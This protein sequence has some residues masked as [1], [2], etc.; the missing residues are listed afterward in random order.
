MIE[1]QNE[2]TVVVA[3][4]NAGKMLDV[5]CRYVGEP[6]DPSHVRQ[7]REKFEGL[8]D[9]NPCAVVAID[10]RN[11]RMATL[12]PGLVEQIIEDAFESGGKEVYEQ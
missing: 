3:S 9:H 7:L 5:V 4:D 8:L 10:L 11:R 6:D 1:I 12:D 2:S